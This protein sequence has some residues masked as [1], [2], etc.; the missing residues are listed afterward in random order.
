MN[1]NISWSMSVIRG[2]AAMVVAA[3][4]AFQIFVLPYLGLGGLPHLLTSLAATYAV[5]LFFV[6]SGFMI[7]WSVQRHTTDGIFDWKGYAIARIL[8]IY[9]PLFAAIVITFLVFSIIKVLG[10]HGSESYR[11]GGEMFVVRER[12]E[13]SLKSLLATV[14]L[15]YGTF[16][17]S[18]P[19]LEMNGPLWTLG[20]E[21]WIYFLVMF[22]IN[23]RHC[24]FW[25][26]L[27]PLVVFLTAS[28]RT[29]LDLQFIFLLVWLCGYA[30]GWFVSSGRV[31]SRG[32][33]LL[34]FVFSGLVFVEMGPAN[35]AEQILNPFDYKWSIVPIGVA[36]TCLVAFVVPRVR[37]QDD[38]WVASS[39][40]YSYTLYL[41]HFPIQLFAFSLLHP[42]L[43]SLDVVWSA[44][45]GFMIFGVCIGCSKLL[46]RVVENRRL[47]RSVL[48]RS[49]GPS[50]P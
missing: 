13:F 25:S 29:G 21:F 39:A 8:R 1:P 28:M 4:H 17:G 44:I 9:P 46:S 20:Y 47:I 7:Y 45:T 2:V 30:L 43:H 49:G 42:I 3:T 48:L 31:L 37:Q 6:V 10:L 19:P 32:M 35:L 15:T 36:M 50:W 16:P 11:L 41:I 33:L 12:A 23:T 14:A 26:G 5:L 18:P 22:A 27:L 24:R 38:G 34:T 40:E